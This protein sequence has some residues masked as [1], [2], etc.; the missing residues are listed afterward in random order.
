M[1]LKLFESSSLGS[2][3][4]R[5]ASAFDSSRMS[6]LPREKLHQKFKVLLRYFID[7]AEDLVK[8]PANIHR[9]SAERDGLGNFHLS[10]I[11]LSKFQELSFVQKLLLTLSY[12]QA[13]SV[14]S[15]GTTN[16]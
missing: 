2:A 15:V 12:G 16:F 8:C 1:L 4:L 14:V 11:K 13:L 6:V 7:L 5:W 3:V 9:F 10:T